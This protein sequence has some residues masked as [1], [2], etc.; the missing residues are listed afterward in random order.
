MGLH[1]GFPLDQCE[2]IPVIR[3]GPFKFGDGDDVL[4]SDYV[5]IETEEAVV[6]AL[7]ALVA[8]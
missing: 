6:E 1:P 4:T 7:Q 5:F 8:H 3:I 2:Y